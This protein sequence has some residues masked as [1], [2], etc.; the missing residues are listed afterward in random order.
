MTLEQ[1]SSNLRDRLSE[2]SV[3]QLRMILIEQYEADEVDVELVKTISAVLE[4]KTE[5]EHRDPEEAYQEFLAHYAGTEPLY[6]E[7]VEEIEE[8]E[9]ISGKKAIRT[10]KAIRF[11]II[12]AAVIALFLASSAV[13]SA[14]GL[15]LWGKL[16]SWTTDNF[17][18]SKQMDGNHG[19]AAEPT[20]ILLE[21]RNMLLE[22]GLPGTMVPTYVPHGYSV[23]DVTAEETFEGMTYSAQLECGDQ[24]GSAVFLRYIVAKAEPNFILPKDEEAPHIVSINGIDFYITTNEGMFRAVWINENLIC[25]ISG[26]KTENELL[27]ILRSIE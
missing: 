10:K 16:V 13:A 14:R 8:R 12:L 6:D 7:I 2:L 17:V 26:V 9:K 15:D 27:K 11:G 3:E 20:D 22:D 18:I 4:S 24:E 19:D 23:V 1:S 21:L 25:D 5:N